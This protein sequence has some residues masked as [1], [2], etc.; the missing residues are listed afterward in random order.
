MVE[1]IL[2]MSTPEVAQHIELIEATEEGIYIY[3]KNGECEFHAWKNGN[4]NGKN[5]ED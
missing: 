1:Q 4:L 3:F 2:T 5:E